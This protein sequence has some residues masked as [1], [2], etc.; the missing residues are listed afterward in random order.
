[1]PYLNYVGLGAFDEAIEVMITN[2]IQMKNIL[3]DILAFG[4]L[5]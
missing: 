5:I 4:S 3:I 2:K 1:M